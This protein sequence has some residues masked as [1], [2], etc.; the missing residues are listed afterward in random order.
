MY[1]PPPR[2]R[3]RFYS[4]GEGPPSPVLCLFL[5]VFSTS[6]LLLLWGNW[7]LHSPLLTCVYYPFFS[8]RRHTRLFNNSWKKNVLLHPCIL[9][10]QHPVALL[11]STAEL[12]AR[13][14]HHIR[15]LLPPCPWPHI[16]LPIKSCK[17]F[18]LNVSCVHPRIHH[19]SPIVFPF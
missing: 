12:L 10:K 7:Y 18:L 19:L 6:T 4:K 14:S 5:H 11:P 13:P 2:V 3:V 1:T 8:D 17:Y 9:L 15:T 16:Q